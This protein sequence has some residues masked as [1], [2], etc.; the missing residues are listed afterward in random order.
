M[1]E[2]VE[3]KVLCRAGDCRSRRSG[4]V[5]LESREFLEHDVGAEDEI[6]RIPQ[7]TLAD[8]RARPLFVR[9]LDKSLDA[10]H[11]G[12]DR[13]RLSR[14]NVTVA[15]RRVVGR[16]AE[17]YDFTGG[18]DITRLHAQ[19]GELLSVIKD[20]VGRE[21]GHDR[22]RIAGRGPRCRGPDRGSA[23]ASLGLEQ[24]RRLGADLPQLL[25]DAKA[26]VEIGNHDRRIEHRRITDHA[27]DR[28]KRRTLAYQGKELL[29]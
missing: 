28:L 6:A 24:D 10:P 13:Q 25:G 20:V 11:A 9:L 12:I 26:I 17:G 14:M 16:D 7:V 1:I 2:H 18:R 8:E 3:A 27:D 21:H 22:L 29:G 5:G 19:P 4:D 15:G 23:V